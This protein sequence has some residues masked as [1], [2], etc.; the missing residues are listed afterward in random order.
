MQD[1]KYNTTVARAYSIKSGYWSVDLDAAAVDALLG[2]E[3]G[4][5]LVLK[6]IPA[7]SRKKDSSPHAYFQVMSPS[8]V[9]AFKDK[10]ADRAKRRDD[11]SDL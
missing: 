9:R 10:V 3:V 4:S 8:E 5:R 6:I 2:A 1:K 11:I 7:E